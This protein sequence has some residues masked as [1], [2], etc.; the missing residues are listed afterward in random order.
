MNKR[1]LCLLLITAIL[2][3]LV[4]CGSEEAT[5]SEETVQETAET[6][7]QKTSIPVSS[8]PDNLLGYNSDTLYTNE[9][10]QIQL[11]LPAD[12]Y[13]Y[14]SSRLATLSGI[15]LGEDEDATQERF[16][17]ALKANGIVYD[18]AAYEAEGEDMV[19]VVFEHMGFL[20][21]EN[22]TEQQFAEMKLEHYSGRFSGIDVGATDLQISTINLAGADHPCLQF[23][24]SD[25]G[26]TLHKTIVFVQTG[27]F[28]AVICA[29][30]PYEGD[31]VS[32]IDDFSYFEAVTADVEEET[33]PEE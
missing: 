3:M 18:M 2:V 25:N 10:L 9:L 15:T 23:I 26:Q 33:T 5:V 31:D 14:G 12:W 4:A 1:W 32:I 27:D 13:F 6:V 7:P 22:M 20:Y 19:S 17:A 21:G 11:E 29:S 24:S 30:S 28:M 16:I 8:V